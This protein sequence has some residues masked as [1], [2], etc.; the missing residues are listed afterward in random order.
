MRVLVAKDPDPKV[1]MRVYQLNLVNGKIDP[2]LITDGVNPD[3]SPAKDELILV[4]PAPKPAASAAPTPPT[5]TPGV[6]P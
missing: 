5:S 3:G 1:S 2:K 6:N 4:K